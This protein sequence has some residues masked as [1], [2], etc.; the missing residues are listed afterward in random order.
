M[1]EAYKDE[2]HMV[3]VI[4]VLGFIAAFVPSE[5]ERELTNSSTGDPEDRAR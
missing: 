4:T 1:S 3:D 5:V 2:S